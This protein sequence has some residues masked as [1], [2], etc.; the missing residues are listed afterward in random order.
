M[1]NQEAANGE[2]R[3]SARKGTLQVHEEKIGSTVDLGRPREAYG[4]E[5]KSGKSIL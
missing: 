2:S 3:H 4:R 5:G 1:L